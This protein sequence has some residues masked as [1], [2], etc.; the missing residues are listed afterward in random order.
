MLAL[1]FRHNQNL[2][3]LRTFAT[4]FT[5]E[6]YSRVR[7]MIFQEKEDKI[8][9]ALRNID[10]SQPHCN[11]LAHTAVYAG[12]INVLKFMLNNGVDVNEIEIIQ[13][14]DEED[15]FIYFSRDDSSLLAFAIIFKADSIIE[16]LLKKGADPNQGQISLNISPLLLA[17]K[18]KNFALAKALLEFG[19]D[20]NIPDIFGQTPLLV[21]CQNVKRQ[22][23]L[24]LFFQKT[25]LEMVKLLLSYNANPNIP[26]KI[27]TYSNDQSKTAM[28]YI[29]EN[30]KLKKIYSK[31]TYSQLIREN[32]TTIEMNKLTSK[33]FEETSALDQEVKDTKPSFK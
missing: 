13:E 19:A 30:R 7:K 11:G 5:P 32:N 29:N 20:P 26:C 14:Y 10:L 15:N 23:P 16:L 17:V 31:V 2:N 24:F 27:D 1:F 18:Q 22:Q 4:T 9:S 3:I 12:K 25:E 21:A 8:I 28:D 33:N 6:D